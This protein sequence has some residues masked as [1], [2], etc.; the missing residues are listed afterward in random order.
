MSQLQ[1]RDGSQVS[2]DHPSSTA[3]PGDQLT[4]GHRQHQ[5]Q[6]YPSGLSSTYDLGSQRFNNQQ[7]QNTQRKPDS[8]FSAS[9]LQNSAIPSPTAIA[10][11]DRGKTP[12][13]PRPPGNNSSTSSR[14]ITYEPQAGRGQ[15]SSPREKLDKLL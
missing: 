5:H 2:D 11:F 15:P 3:I 6:P 7:P 13:F 8:Q 1:L 12:S 4:A 14:S 10:G 9:G